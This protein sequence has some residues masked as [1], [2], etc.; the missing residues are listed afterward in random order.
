MDVNVG[1]RVNDGQTLIV[2]EA[3]KME[4]AIESDER[5]RGG[6]NSLYA[7][8]FGIGGTGA[9]YSAAGCVNP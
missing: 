4:I 7:G 2:V 9:D 3:M 6:R 1:E 8:Q 5:G